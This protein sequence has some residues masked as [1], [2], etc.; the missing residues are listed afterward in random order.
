MG[1]SE[2]LILP[3]TGEATLRVSQNNLSMI[4]S[5]PSEIENQLSNSY[6]KLVEQDRW[7]GYRL[8]RLSI[9]PLIRN[10]SGQAIM[11]Q[12]IDVQIDFPQM[13]V[14]LQSAPVTAA[15][16]QVLKN[17]L[18]G[19]QAKGWRDAKKI[20]QQQALQA[21][22]LDVK[23]FRI[24]IRESGMYRLSYEAIRDAG[25]QPSA[26]DPSTM[27]L[28]Y[29]GVEQPMYFAGDADASFEAGEAF[30][31]WGERLSGENGEWFHDETDENV[32]QAVQ[33]DSPGLR[34]QTRQVQDDAAAP[35]APFF[36]E[37]THLETDLRYYHG[38]NDAD[39]F[40]TARIPGE[41][42]MWGALSGT[43]SL[44]ATLNLPGV[45]TTAPECSLRARVRGIT[46]DSIKPNH[47][48]QIFLNSQ[49]V[50]DAKFADNAEVILRSAFPANL[51][52][53]GDNEFRIFSVGDT[54][55]TIDQFYFDWVEIDYW[56]GYDA[57]GEQLAFIPP[58]DANSGQIRYQITGLQNDEIIVFDLAS[59]NILTGVTVTDDGAGNYSAGFTDS[60]GIPHEYLAATALS[61]RQPDAIEPVTPSTWRDAS[62]FAD[63][64][65][66]SHADFM[67]Q[68]QRLAAYRR[69]K[70]DFEVVVVDVQE[71]YDEFL[72]G[73]ES[74]Q[75]IRNFLV[76]AFHNWQSP[77]PQYVLLM[78]DGSWDPKKNNPQTTKRSFVPAIGN[79]VSDNRLV[80]I[81]GPDD[82]IPDM[83]IGRIAVETSPQAEAIVDKII[84]YEA[85]PLH[86][87]AK[88]FTFLNGGISAFE[89]K[90]FFEQSEKLI[91]N[92]I[93]T[94]PVQGKPSRIYKTSEGRVPGELLPDILSAIDAGTSIMA[95]SGHAGSQTWELMM[96]N[97]DIPRVQNFGRLPFIASMTCHT[98]RFAE[99]AQTSFGEEFL[100][101]PDRGAAAFWGTSGWGFAFQDGVLLDGLFRAVTQDT[102]RFVGV[103]TTIAKI[104]LWQQYGDFQTN[105]NLIDQYTLL[106]DPAL[107]LALPAKPDLTLTA[108]GISTFPVN[109]TERDSLV[110]VNVVVRNR[111]LTTIDSTA[112][113][114]KARNAEDDALR[115][116]TEVEIGSVG[117]ED[118]VSVGWPGKDRRG[119]YVVETEIDPFDVI[120]EVS[121]QNNRAQSRVNFL[122]SGLTI[123]APRQM[124]VVPGSRPEL[125]V[126]NPEVASTAS[127]EFYFEIDSTER[128]D[129]ALLLA[130]GAN[131]EQVVRT[132]WQVT[133]PLVDGRYY[134][135]AHSQENGVSSGWQSA[136]FFVD[137]DAGMPGFQQS[138]QDWQSGNGN[139]AIADSG[140]TLRWDGD[141]QRFHLSGDVFSP[142]IGPAKSWQRFRVDE[143]MRK[144][145]QGSGNASAR[146][147]IQGRRRAGDPWQ[148][149]KSDLQN[150]ASLDD[151]DASRFPFLRLKAELQDDD[152]L[153]SPVIHSWRV[154]F[155]PLGDF[156]VSGRYVVEEADSLLP[157]ELFNISAKVFYFGE[158]KP[159]SATVALSLQGGQEGR[160]IIAQKRFAPEQ[161]SGAQVQF[162]W[163]NE[164]PGDFRL[165]VEADPANEVPE[166]YNFNNSA[167]LQLHVRRDNIPPRLEITFDGREVFEQSSFV[168][169]RPEIICHIYDENSLAIRD[170]S[171]VSVFIDESRI[172]YT[173]PFIRPQLKL[174]PQGEKRA[175]VVLHPEFEA[176]DH[177]VTFLV[178]DAFGNRAVKSATVK[179][180][181]E[182]ALQNVLNYP[183]PF[184]RETEFTFTLSQP[185]DEV[186][187]K[188][189]TV[190]GR[191][192]QTLEVFGAQPGFNRIRWDG[193]DTDG[194]EIANG[195]YLYKIIARQG[196][197][198]VERIEKLAVA[199]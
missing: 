105:I 28:F 73:L 18:N 31:F 131:A 38:D 157:G 64:I 151:I 58:E 50:T 112:L 49:L 187:I 70:N 47:H 14:A 118:T 159:D 155:D 134:W 165:F 176:G 158:N 137:A 20:H 149:I 181:A 95:F 72:F 180:S 196:G 7:R 4:E 133:T 184:D 54:P 141:N 3:P 5:L 76:H 24:K 101:L 166:P 55:A 71:I 59:G 19:Q 53:D 185:A 34:F 99:P 172:A 160:A 11:A 177:M 192:I 144:L 130:S 25:G 48:V 30:W 153:D 36:L 121:E 162:Q 167:A 68:A 156:V 6:A 2:I 186:R 90:L 80:C 104:G 190:A 189:Y 84:A 171:H 139:F 89:H 110:S 173:D 100:R 13:P 199:R 138:G 163:Q 65:V 111:G 174:L 113:V 16:Q 168:A 26:T 195:V 56:R 81:D 94:P 191:L 69:Q 114:Y 21:F 86:D 40:T 98:A 102:V 93:E 179:V 109:P 87:W 193:R 37:K 124:E 127:R 12:S 35:T 67:E 74:A 15:E 91:R 33:G 197:K 41:G 82:F 32:Y 85:M 44:P 77:A 115:F 154:D 120:D 75:A 57:A 126:Y 79:P 27:Q 164:Q 143:G 188:I 62:N 182:L 39:I 78:G 107:N 103:A 45:V 17:F 146:Y 29:R 117:Y 52:R 61:I 122:A 108:D 148:A 175:E 170:T 198:Q 46:R 152:G 9:N 145:P 42:W 96:V 83:F 8:T 23:Y 106:G 161:D 128:F 169:R 142:A 140:A 147:F 183:N 60:L 10:A 123:A 22:P 97:E 135:R 116:Q 150:Q 132:G 178:N 136:S 119:E 125:F 129:S 88:D 194:D 63:L 43:E 1:H 51:L 66:I 92:F